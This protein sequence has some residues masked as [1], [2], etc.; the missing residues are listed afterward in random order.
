MCPETVTPRSKPRIVPKGTRR[1]EAFNANI[2][3]LYARGLSTRDIG[4][5]PKTHVRR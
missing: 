3:A 2:V 1:L 5:E 4:L